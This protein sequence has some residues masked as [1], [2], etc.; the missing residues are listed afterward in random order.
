[1]NTIES[2][3]QEVR[4]LEAKVRQLSAQRQ[5]AK[6]DQTI[7]TLQ[8]TADDM[9]HQVKAAAYVNYQQSAAYVAGLK[10][11]V[12]SA[13]TT[14]TDL[15]TGRELAVKLADD[16]TTLQ[17]FA[18][19]IKEGSILEIAGKSYFVTEYAF[20]YAGSQATLLPANQKATIAPQGAKTTPYS[21]KDCH[22]NPSTKKLT[23]SKR[24]A[25]QTGDIVTIAGKKYVPAFTYL[26]SPAGLMQYELAELEG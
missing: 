22:F 13:G 9:A 19:G 21:A 4:E 8:K 15:L 23:L 18:D 26:Q 11:E 20:S 16:R 24:D 17:T 1:M 7:S 5:K 25:I 12:K 6:L 14:A 2:I 3:M 10:A